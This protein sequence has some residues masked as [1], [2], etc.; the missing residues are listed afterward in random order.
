[1]EPE[2]RLRSQNID[3]LPKNTPDSKLQKLLVCLGRSCR[4]YNSEQVFNN[5]KRNVPPNTELISIGCLGQCGNGPMVLV[6]VK[7]KP[8]WYSEVH[9]DEVATIVKQHLIGKSPVKKMLYPKFHPQKY[10]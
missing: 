1:M 7:S 10:Q 4:K 8:I 9:P 3:R 2:W 5:F 6:E